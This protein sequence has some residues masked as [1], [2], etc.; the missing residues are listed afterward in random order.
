MAAQGETIFSIPKCLCKKKK[1]SVRLWMEVEND[2][3]VKLRACLIPLAVS[4]F[5]VGC[6]V[7]FSLCLCWPRKIMAFHC[8]RELP[9]ITVPTY[10][11][12][13]SGVDGIF[14]IRFDS[15]SYPIG[16]DCHTSRF[17]ANA[18]HL[19]QDLKLRAVGEVKGINRG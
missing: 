3:K 11:A 16:V 15:K 1:P 6:S 18:P 19:F 13:L 8:L 7:E 12:L 5:K 14:A 2:G 10:N 4:L 9:S 17:I